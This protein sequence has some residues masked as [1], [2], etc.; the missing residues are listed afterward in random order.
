MKNGM[1]YDEGYL[2]N[3]KIIDQHPDSKI[4]F[5]NKV[6]PNYKECVDLVLKLHK[7]IPMVR[8]VGWDVI[9]DQ[10]DHPLVMEW[11]GYSNDIKFS[12]ATQGPCFKDL[13]WDNLHK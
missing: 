6:I 8:S 11:N 10:E 13:G 12:E 2:A 3:W 4:P 9:V 7:K 5:S 1:L